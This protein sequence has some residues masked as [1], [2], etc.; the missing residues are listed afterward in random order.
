MITYKTA[1]KFPQKEDFSL[2]VMTGLPLFKEGL[3]P[4]IRFLV[5]FFR[6]RS[7]LITEDYITYIDY[8]HL[9]VVIPKTYIYDIAS[10]PAFVPGT[11]HDGPLMYGSCPHDMGY[12]FG[13]LFLSAG[14]TGTFTF[15][16]IS[17]KDLDRL[18]RRMNDKSNKMPRYNKLAE[19]AVRWFGAR[20]YG[21]EQIEQS[22]WGNRRA[23][24][25]SV[26]KNPLQS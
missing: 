23:Y 15:H 24:M 17:R 25:K 22:K 19:L 9:Y 4:V 13:G 20:N 5:S 12:E 10:I 7:Y 6:R 8:L 2:P 3:H 26:L 16:R 18:F 14:T 11:Q 21:R 1:A